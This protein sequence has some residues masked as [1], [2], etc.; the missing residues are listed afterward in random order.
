M[1]QYDKIE[2]PKDLIDEVRMHGLSTLQEDICRAQDI[3][4]RAPLEDLI[5]LA[6]DNG[7]QDRDGTPNPDGSWSGGRRGTSDTFYT[8]IYTIWN[9][10]DATRFFNEHS[11]PATKAAKETAAKLNRTEEELS[12]TSAELGTLRHNYHEMQEQYIAEHSERV[13]A[14]TALE[15]AQREILALKAKLYD[16]TVA[17]A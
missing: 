7:R 4:G 16:L 14:A 1:S 6:K 12:T 2:T 11:N 17:G 9:W 5:A 8:I 3:F 13:N 10:L 15:A